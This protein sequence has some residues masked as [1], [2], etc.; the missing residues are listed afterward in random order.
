MTLFKNKYRIESTRLKGWDYSAAGYYFIT[1]CTKNRECILGE[2]VGGDVCLSN[3]GE[4]V[5]EEWLKTPQIRLNVDLDEWV[6]MPNHFHGIIILKSD[7]NVETPCR[8][9]ETPRRGVSTGWKPD[10]LGSIV[11]QFKSVCTKR[12]WAMGYFDFVWQ[13]RFYDH[14]I[15]D[16]ASLQRIRR[17]ISENPI[18]WAQDDNN[19]HHGS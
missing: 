11:N 14:I 6:I 2:L 17:Y 18:K 7:G 9:V 10:S 16:E 3:I 13:S 4:I 15:Q 5:A 1:I 12:I 19:P 8:A